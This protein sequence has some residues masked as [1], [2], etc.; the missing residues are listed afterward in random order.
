[1][2]DHTPTILVVDDVRMFRDLGALFL[3]GLGRVLTASSGEQALELAREETPDLVLTDL[4][5]PGMDG[6]TLCREIKSEPSLKET[7]VIVMIGS[8][9]AAERSDVIR[10]GADD[11]LEKPLARASLI[12]TVSRFLRDDHPRGLPRVVIDTPVRMVA[13]DDETWG[14][15]RNLSRGGLFIETQWSLMPC[16]EVELHFRLPE[17]GQPVEPNAQVVWRRMPIG[18]SNTT[19]AGIGMRFLDIDSPTV[20][21][22]ED[23]VYERSSTRP[24]AASQGAAE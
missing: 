6:A 13:G 19:P 17:S 18:A 3:A 24:S 22:V 16:E 23:F 5:M 7:A 11:V 10:S 20:R 12:A 1:M 9:E 15:V 2:G 8:G 21:I 4:R 14:T